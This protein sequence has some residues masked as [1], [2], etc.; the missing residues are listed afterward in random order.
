MEKV[1]MERHGLVISGLTG[2]LTG[3]AAAWMV[4]HETPAAASAAA[5]PTVV[6]IAVTRADG[7]P[8]AAEPTAPAV[9][10]KRVETLPAELVDLNAAEEKD[11]RLVQDLGDGRTVEFTVL[12]KLQRRAEQILRKAEVPFGAL[13]AMEPNTGRLLAY[14]E[15]STT[16]PELRGIPGLA[17]PPAAS[18]FKLVTAAALLEHANV[19]P[20][21]EVCYHGGLRGI[22]ARHLEDD[23]RLDTLCQTLSEALGKSTNAVFGKLTARH[24]DAGVLGRYAR[25]FG[26]ER[27]LPF[28]KPL[29]TS[30]AVFSGDRVKLAQTAAGFY[31]TQLSP[32]HGLLLAASIANRAVM[33]SPQLVARYESNGETLLEPVTTPIGRAVRERT[34]RMLAQMMVT[35]TEIGTAGPYFRKRDKSLKGIR[36]AGKTGSL[37]APAADGERH[38]FSWWVGFAPAENPRIAVAAM[39]VNVGKWRIKSTYL[40]REALET[41]FEETQGQQSA[42]ARR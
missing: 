40:A 13:V 35:T 9:D 37:S 42:D 3:L 22:G 30:H 8:T 29:Q 28:I 5:A 24:L 6:P 7:P 38:H 39:V 36:I 19:A 21:H 27:K 10:A 12:P 1:A 16:M 20:D 31:N 26:W 25:R 41:Y 2:F 23:P 34:A 11:G 17:N 33:V 15:H 32:M 18:I 14:A 4:W